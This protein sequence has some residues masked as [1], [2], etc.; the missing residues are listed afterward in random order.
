MQ[1]AKDFRLPYF[2]WAS[3]PLLGGS[4]FPALFTSA[5]IGV[6]DV[7]GKS[8]S[9]DNP[10]YRFDFHPVNPAPGDF[11]ANVRRRTAAHS[12]S[13]RYFAPESVNTDLTRLAVEQISHDRSLPC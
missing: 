8:K 3:K 2:D 9:I 11:D 12:L 13:L 6:T 1:A 7:D 5:Q 4:A 10:L